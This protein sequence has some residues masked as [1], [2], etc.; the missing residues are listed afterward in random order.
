[1]SGSKGLA[2][3]M[4]PGPSTITATFGYLS[5]TTTLTCS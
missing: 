2:T 4:N 5:G 1:M 3:C